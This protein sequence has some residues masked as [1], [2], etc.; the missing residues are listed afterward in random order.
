MC[1]ET[2]QVRHSYL[3]GWLYMLTCRFLSFKV[4]WFHSRSLLAFRRSPRMYCELSYTPISPI[5]RG[6]FHLLYKYPVFVNTIFSL[7]CKILKVGMVLVFAN[8]LSG[9][10]HSGYP[11]SSG[12]TAETGWAGCGLWVTRLAKYFNVGTK[13]SVSRAFIFYIHYK[14]FTY[15]GS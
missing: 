10:R 13:E 9:T 8:F 11:E 5:K 6:V 15:S 1:T 14:N 12:C 2:S 3:R 4:S 7:V